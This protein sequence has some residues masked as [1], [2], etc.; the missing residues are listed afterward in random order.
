MAKQKIAILGGGVGAMTAA[1][2]ITD[3]PGWQNQYDI[4][5][6]Q[7]GWR[8]G[9]KGASG[10]NHAIAD[11]IQEHG[12]HVWM[13]FYENAF[14]VM[15]RAY[16]YCRNNNLT[17]GT[18]FPSYLDAFTKMPFLTVPELVNGEWKIWPVYWTPNNDIPGQDNP[19]DAPS[20][21]DGTPWG[22]IRAIL[23]FIR[24]D[25]DRLC[26]GEPL[27]QGIV[28]DLCDALMALDEYKGTAGKDTLLHRVENFAAALPLDPAK[29]PPGSLDLLLKSLGC[30]HDKLIEL[31]EPSAKSNDDIRRLLIIISTAWGF[32]HGIACDGIL[33]NGF[34]AIEDED[35]EQW[36]ARNGCKY[37]PSPLT[38]SMY[39]AAFA[40]QH[41]DP[42]QKR[43]G[44]GSFLHGWLRLMAS[45]RGSLMWWMNAGMGD[46]IFT[47]IYKALAHRGV[48]FEFFRKVTRLVPSASGSIDA[49]EIDVQANVRP[50][51]GTYDPL[52]P[53][54]GLLCWPSEPNYDQ[55]VE[56]RQLRD[57][58]YINRDLE[59]WWTDL[60]AFGSIRLQ[61]GRD[62]D[63]VI[64]GISFGALKYICA[65]L[66]A[67]D[68][69]RGWRGMLD[70]L[71]AI[72]T[73]AF[74]LWL[75]K[76]KEELGWNPGRNDD[77]VMCGYL[78][79]FDTWG[80][81]THLIVR[82]NWTPQDNVQQNP[83]WCNSAPDDP[84][85]APF[86]DP[87]YPATQLQ[88]VTNN[89]ANFLNGP[90]GALWPKAVINGQFDWGLLVNPLNITP[91]IA[92]QWIRVNI[93]PSELYVLTVPGSTKYRLAPWDSRFENLI[94]AGDWT[95]TEV[96]LG[97]V[98][99]AVQSGK[100][101]A[102]ALTGS[103]TFIY[104]S[105]RRQIPMKEAPMRVV[106]RAAAP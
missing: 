20:P 60:P 18:P 23:Q 6:Y 105:Y 87:S 90:V 88:I 70:N 104:G 9:G 94:L 67:A 35:F 89:A 2:E 68:A 61:A 66:P 64:L 4:T 1:F 95:L 98:E 30:F 17:P 100:M 102:Y 77:P 52:V 74:Q 69:S 43:G 31:A 62:F 48:K 25:F 80:D 96:N 58:K 33:E 27:I 15:R 97:C 51:V 85:Q 93:D 10:R 11:R 38:V 13:G 75:N 99:A 37:V 73:Q 79:P 84:Q 86:S 22:Y 45:Y 50:E 72:R 55:L 44:A 14:D 39:D 7:L 78:E 53:V 46:T 8:L 92:S 83:Y 34:G 59:S 71:Q 21:A 12:L 26:D 81:E 103:P 16:D 32:I 82:E 40:Y 106:A 41:G 3:Q 54:K 36:L 49:I 56:A 91:P 57:P 65:D 19:T 76:T 42:Q 101:A 63:K 47:P 5:V 28:D 24:A 29:H